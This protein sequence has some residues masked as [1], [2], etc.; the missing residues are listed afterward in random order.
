M[1][2]GNSHGSRVASMKVFFERDSVHGTVFWL[3]KRGD[4]ITVLGYND[5]KVLYF[6]GGPR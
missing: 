2:L 6:Q 3:T 5:C 4:Y 1:V